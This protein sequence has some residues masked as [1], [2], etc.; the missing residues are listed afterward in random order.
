MVI[1]KDLSF[2]L[3]FYFI[4]LF[5]N[6]SWGY[7]FIVR[8]IIEILPQ[9]TLNCS[10]S[11]PC[12]FCILRMDFISS[13][14]VLLF[15]QWSTFLSLGKP[16]QLVVTTTEDPPCPLT[17]LPLCKPSPNILQMILIHLSKTEQ[18]WQCL[19]TL[20]K[21]RVMWIDVSR[22]NMIPQAKRML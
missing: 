22:V 1:G 10:S 8:Y 11:L 6:E 2:Y 9:I 19:S 16:L 20:P 3:L 15:P 12:T 14:A 5:V 13:N 17:S 21:S 4:L 18:N 7:L